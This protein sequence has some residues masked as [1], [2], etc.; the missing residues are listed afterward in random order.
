[1]MEEK[2]EFGKG[3]TY[4]LG[5]FL[6]HSTRTLPDIPNFESKF[7]VWFNGASDHLY[8]I[9][10][11]DSF[12]DEI[13]KRVQILQGKSFHWG[14]GFNGPFATKDDAAWALQEAK[15]IL[16]LIDKHIGVDA[17]KGEYE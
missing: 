5:L 15:D 6:A 9:I 1:M 3:L 14:H 8:G 13:K 7:N 11:P 16:L 12:P 2:S 17:I 4:C 10:V